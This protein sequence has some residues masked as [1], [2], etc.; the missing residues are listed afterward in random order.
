MYSQINLTSYECALI[1]DKYVNFT[2]IFPSKEYQK[3]K[4]RKIGIYFDNVAI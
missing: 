3:K 1:I 2:Y 4:L